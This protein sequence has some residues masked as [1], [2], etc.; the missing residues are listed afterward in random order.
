MSANQH[1]KWYLSDS[2]RF[3]EKRVKFRPWLQ[4]IVA[5]LNVN[6]SDNNVSVQ[7]WYLHSWLEG[8]AL[9]QVT[10]WIVA[11]IKLNKVLN[12][13]IIEELIDQLQ[14]TYNDS[15]SK[16]RVTC[17]LKALKQKEKSFTKHLITFKQTLL[18]AEGL[19]WDDAVKK[20]FLNNS[21]NAILTQALIVI[22]IS[23]LYDEYII[24][25]QWVSHNLNLIQ[26]AATQECCMTTTIITQQ[27]YTDNINWELIEHIIVTATETEER[28]RA[29]W[30]SEKKVVKCCT[31]WLCMHCRDNDHFIKNCKLLSAVWPHIIN[32]A[33]VETVKKMTE[34]E[35]NSEKE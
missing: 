29:Q 24:L 20:T 18:K 17:T 11:C 9:S 22:S 19:K 35:K 25:L 13:M 8:L 3:E 7:F 32:V 6:M 15:E 5:K 33:A 23:V 27:S 16:K 30:V 1:S 31:K 12:H 2:L 26:K 21:L 14:H 10:S 28:C 34:E 4:Q